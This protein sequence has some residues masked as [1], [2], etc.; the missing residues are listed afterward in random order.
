MKDILLS[1]ITFIVVPLLMWTVG[2]AIVNMI[3]MDFVMKLA[4]AGIA[5]CG[6]YV[7]KR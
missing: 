2:Q 4:Y 5:I 7:L 3:T 6:I 1:L